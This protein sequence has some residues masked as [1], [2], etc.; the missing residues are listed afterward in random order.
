MPNWGYLLNNFAYNV[1]LALWIGGAVALG[2]LAAPQLFRT[3]PRP[4]AGATFGPMLRKFARIRLV[5][6]V[7]AIA[8]AA[9]KH[10]LWEDGR[11]TAWIALR[12]VALGVMA[13]SILYEVGYLERALE[14]R[15][16][17][18]TADM[19][20]SDPHRRAFN[21][22]HRRAEGL[23]KVSIGAAVVALLLS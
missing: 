2:A 11:S 3:L 18:L 19:P 10:F 16:V 14:A 17:H 5:T 20:E 22:L 6:L 21:T 9:V 1:S 13:A 15:R 8:A 4:Q 12:W 7:I 23:M